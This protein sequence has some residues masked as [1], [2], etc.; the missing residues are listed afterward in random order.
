MALQEHRTAVL[1]AHFRSTT[2]IPIADAP[3]RV[4]FPSPG[5]S[6]ERGKEMEPEEISCVLF[7]RDGGAR[8]RGHLACTW[9]LPNDPQEGQKAPEKDP[10]EFICNCS[11]ATGGVIVSDGLSGPKNV[12]NFELIAATSDSYPRWLVKPLQWA[13]PAVSNDSGNDQNDFNLLRRIDL[14]GACVVERIDVK[15]TR[16]SAGS[17]GVGDVWERYPFIFWR[18]TPGCSVIPTGP[19]MLPAVDKSSGGERKQQNSYELVLMQLLLPLELLYALS[20]LS[21]SQVAKLASSKTAKD[22]ERDEDLP[23]STLRARF[24]EHGVGCMSSCTRGPVVSPTDVVGSVDRCFALCRSRDVVLPQRLGCA[25]LRSAGFTGD[26]TV[27]RAV[28]ERLHTFGLLREKPNNNNNNNNNTQV[29]LFTPPDTLGGFAIH[30]LGGGKELNDHPLVAVAESGSGELMDLVLAFPLDIPSAV[31]AWPPHNADRVVRKALIRAARHGHSDVVQKLLRL[32]CSDGSDPS[33]NGRQ[34]DLSLPS[35]RNHRTS[36]PLVVDAVTSNDS[37]TVGLLLDYYE[38]RNASA[39][40]L[41]SPSGFSPLHVAVQLDCAD[42][43][44]A[45]CE[46]DDEGISPCLAFGPEGVNDPE[47]LQGATPLHLAIAAGSV[48]SVLVLLNA[49]A[50]LTAVAGPSTSQMTPLELGLVKRC[51]ESTGV[52]LAWIADKFYSE[53]PRD[54]DAEYREFW[55]RITSTSNYVRH[56]ALHNNHLLYCLSGCS[57]TLSEDQRLVGVRYVFEVL[58]GGWCR[59]GEAAEFP[60]DQVFAE[61][62]DAAI[63]EYLLEHGWNPNDSPGD[64][65]RGSSALSVACNA[66][67]VDVLR[68]LLDPAAG[69]SGKCPVTAQTATRL[70]ETGATPLALAC[71]NGSLECVRELVS[72]LRDS[73]SR[74]AP[75]SSGGDIVADPFF[76]GKIPYD[77]LSMVVDTDLSKDESRE[78]AVRVSSPEE[79]AD[80]VRF[81]VES[82]VPVDSPG[83]GETAL[84]AA[85]GRDRHLLLV[86]RLLDLGADPN[87]RGPDGLDPL[88]LAAAHNRADLVEALL[89]AGADCRRRASDGRT[90]DEFATASHVISRLRR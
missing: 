19:H 46:P 37:D 53:E 59:T 50:S 65:A 70:I 3:L 18:P 77:L 23:L 15:E 63:L 75:G 69:E 60:A 11:T 83:S 43:V 31:L 79:R 85:C 52:L 6:L 12:G 1:D 22:E 66:G 86:Q 88:H 17:E 55:P 61:N 27:L 58:Q 64:A 14:H 34:C 33:Q 29:P 78:E 76:P 20:E 62:G 8:R 30:P 45:L 41:K 35:L 89:G 2:A 40:D 57:E 24:E 68:L 32:D 16:F 4:P 54:A 80:V 51:F 71:G 39:S 28:F 44:A 9:E 73:D 74:F 56:S 82:G 90:P 25:L 26:P 47:K 7:P 36:N 13:T 42:V 67:Q 48:Q 49:D 81:L 10:K 84:L 5:P 38:R 87:R 21:C 72:A